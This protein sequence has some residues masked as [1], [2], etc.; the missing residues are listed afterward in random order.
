MQLDR[1][2]RIFIAAAETGSF[3]QASERVYLTHTAVIKSIDKLEDDLR[4]RL[5]VRTPRGVR[6]TEAGKRL[7]PEARK[8]SGVWQ[9]IGLELQALES[10][11]KRTVRFGSSVLC[12][13]SP[14]LLQRSEQGAAPLWEIEVV[15]VKTEEQRIEDVGQDFD[16]LVTPYDMA[17]WKNQELSFSQ[18]GVCRFC[19]A[20]NRKHPLAEKETVGWKDL[21]GETLRVMQTGH[22]PLND[23]IR[24]MLEKD[25]PEIKLL[26]IPPHHNFET[27]NAC[28]KAG[29]FLL[30]LSCWKDV[31]PG[32]VFRT[33]ETDLVMPY[34]LVC[35]KDSPLAEAFL[36]DMN[37]YMNK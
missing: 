20:V 28:A 21:E 22:S 16:F 34:G 4:V 18:T 14:F 33:A 5:F 31:H 32:L 6:L 24:L 12:P 2:L 25:Y 9:K 13:A 10:A 1:L 30:T 37:L 8:I 15:P 26:E 35:R 27:F 11:G 23:E 3:T 17:V 29:D 36:K 19:V 7:L